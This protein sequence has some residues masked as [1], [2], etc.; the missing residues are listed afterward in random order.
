MY[1]NRYYSQILIK[2]KTSLRIS[3]KYSNAK[4]LENPTSGSRVISCRRTDRDD[5]TYNHF[6]Q[7]CEKRL[8]L[9]YIDYLK[10]PVFITDVRS[11]F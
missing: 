1:R 10:F 4:F 9:K 11:G 6:S 7:F 3:G 5:E 8:K 2:I